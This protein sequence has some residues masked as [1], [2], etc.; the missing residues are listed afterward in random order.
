MPIPGS[1][2]PQGVPTPFQLQNRI[3]ATIGGP[4]SIPK[5][6]NG[7]NKT[8]FFFAY[9]AYREPRAAAD[10]AHGED[11][12]GG[13]GSVHLHAHRAELRTTV[14]LLNIGTIGNTGI[15]PAINATTMGALYENRSAVGLYQRRLR[16]RRCQ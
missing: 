5:L 15:K 10:R 11:S 12:R 16:R 9:Q 8:F 4:A 7:K 2:T 6:Y 3:G 13:A 14:N 1:I